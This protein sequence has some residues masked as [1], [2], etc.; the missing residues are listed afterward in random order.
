[1]KALLSEKV[2]AF[3]LLFGIVVNI[4]NKNA[5][6][7]EVIQFT[8]GHSGT[9]R[10]I[11]NK[12]NTAFSQSEQV[13]LK[14]KIDVVKE[15][16]H[17]ISIMGKQTGKQ[18]QESVTALPQLNTRLETVSAELSLLRL[19]LETNSVRNLCMKKELQG[20]GLEVTTITADI[21]IF[22]F[23][24]EFSKLYNDES[25]KLSET[26]KKFTLLAL[27]RIAVAQSLFTV[28]ALIEDCFSRLSEVSEK[29]EE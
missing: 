4:D 13:L 23:M 28:G 19:E 10:S 27:K 9:F 24:S 3:F 17:S 29:T 12:I 1:M 16:D 11:L 8:N 21:D 26:E 5:K 18:L 25:V 7:E 22:S 15:R 14:S 20:K 2:I 6:I